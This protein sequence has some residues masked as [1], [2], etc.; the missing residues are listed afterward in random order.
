MVGI[1]VK[2]GLQTLI[3]GLGAIGSKNDHGVYTDSPLSHAGAILQNKAFELV[4]AVDSNKE[5][6]EKFREK[7]QCN[8]PILNSVEDIRPDI[9]VDIAIV[10][11]S[12]HTHFSI[13]SKLFSLKNL[14]IIFCEKPFCSNANEAQKLITMAEKLGIEIVVNYHR[15]WNSK[16][17]RFRQKIQ[18]Y[19]QPAD[20]QVVYRKGLYNY[21]SHIIDLMVSFWGPIE[22]ITADALRLEHNALDDPSISASIE[23]LSG[24]RARINGCDNV[25]YDLFDMDISYRNC[26]FRIEAGGYKIKKFIEVSDLYFPGYS[27]L[28]EIDSDYESGSVLELNKAYEELA[29]FL[30]GKITSVTSSAENALHVIHVLDAIRDSAMQGGKLIKL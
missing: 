19:G 24:G 1:R 16:F 22:T 4:A 5:S 17:N 2:V 3:V 6:R 12:T 11:S 25:D 10:A 23:F 13:I 14:K 15:R 28:Q 26:R 9:G 7:W 27:Y 8:I 30:H 18:S 29:S 21:G 20:V